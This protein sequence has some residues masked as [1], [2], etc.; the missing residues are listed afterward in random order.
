MADN[1]NFRDTLSPAQQTIHDALCDSAWLSGLKYGWNAGIIKDSDQSQAEYSKLSASRTGH[2]Q[3]YRQSRT[4]LSQASVAAALEAAAGVLQSE[5]AAGEKLDR[6]YL[7][8]T[9]TLEMVHGWLRRY[10][11]SI[12]A[13][14]APGQHDALQAA[15]DAAKAE[16]REED[17]AKLAEFFDWIVMHKAGVLASMSRREQAEFTELLGTARVAQIGAKP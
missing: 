2:L 8:G 10:A 9:V 3:G 6:A 1:V 14:I 12:R 5:V 15:I 11:N 13:L 16:A 4:D 17:A 7:E